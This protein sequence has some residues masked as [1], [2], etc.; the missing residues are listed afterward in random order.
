M[1]VAHIN[2]FGKPRANIVGLT[3]TLMVSITILASATC[4][5]TTTTNSSM[6]INSDSS[7]KLAVVG[8]NAI[9]TAS[10]MSNYKDWPMFQHDLKR[11]G[12]SDSH[13]P[14]T[15]NVLWLGTTGGYI[16]SSPAVKNGKVFVGSYDRHVYAFDCNDGS[17]IWRTMIGDPGGYGQQIYASPA[18]ANGLVFIGCRGIENNFYALYETNGTIKWTFSAEGPVD[19]SPAVANNCVYFGSYDKHVYAIDAITGKLQWAHNTATDGPAPPG[20]LGIRSSPA[21]NISTGIVYI[22]A[23]NGFVYAFDIEGFHDG[24]NDGWSGETGTDTSPTSTKADII[25]RKY[26]GDVILAS[27][28]LAKDLVIIGCNDHKLYA[29]NANNGTIVWATY[30]GGEIRSSAAVDEQRNL[31]VVGTRNYSVCALD[32]DTGKQ[33]WMVKTN[34]WVD[35]S[36]AIA[37]GMVFVGS[38]DHMVYALDEVTGDLIWSYDAQGMVSSSPAIADGRLFIGSDNGTLFAFGTPDLKLDQTDIEFS[39]PEPY[40]GETIEIITTIHNIGEVGAS[41]LVE[42]YYANYNN[43]IRGTIGSKM[44][45]VNARSIA[46]ITID[47]IALRPPHPIYRAWY[48]WVFITATDPAEANKDNNAAFRAIEVLPLPTE[49]WWMFQRDPAHL[50]STSDKGSDTNHI[51]WIFDAGAPIYTSPTVMRGRVFIGTLDKKVYAL[52]EY[53]RTEPPMPPG[54]DE[55]TNTEEPIEAPEICWYYQTNGK[56]TVSPATIYNK[57]FIG[58]NDGYLYALDQNGI[59]DSNMPPITD[60]DTSGNADVIWTFYA[61]NISG[62]PT[63]ANGTVYITAEGGVLYAIDEDNGLE[64]WRFNAGTEIPTS[65]AIAEHLLVIGTLAGEVIAIDRR[66]GT[67][68]WCYPTAGSIYSSPTIA[69][70]MVFIGSS[71]GAIYALDA[72]PDDN[73]DGV[74]DYTGLYPDIDDG[75]PEPA[76]VTYDLIWKYVTAGEVRASPAIANNGMLIVG[77]ADHYVYALNMY[78][79]SLIWKFETGD[80]VTG[81]PAIAY[82]HDNISDSKV[83]IGSEDHKIYALPLIDPDN[84]GIITD[85]ETIWSYELST[86]IIT[87]PAIDNGYVFVATTDGMLYAFG[88]PNRAPVAVIDAP[89]NGTKYLTTAK[90]IFDARS[91]YDP[92]GDELSYIWTSSLCVEPI[93]TQPIFTTTLTPGKHII[94]L[95]VDD[96]HGGKAVAKVT[97]IIYEPRIRTYDATILRPDKP[98]IN[99]SCTLCYGGEIG[100]VNI[101]PVANPHPEGELNGSLGIFVQIMPEMIEVMAWANITITYTSADLPYRMNEARLEMYYWHDNRWKLCSKNNDMY[102]TRTTGVDVNNKYV[103]ANVT[104]LGYIY[105]PG[106]F[107]N[108][109]PVLSQSKVTRIGITPTYRFSVV[110]TDLDNE[111]PTYIT[112][113]IDNTIQ[114]PMK[115]VAIYDKIPADGNEY[116]V[117]GIY[118]RPGRHYYMFDANDG[119]VSATIGTG[120]FVYNITNTIPVANAGAD[121][122]VIVNEPVLFSAYRSYDPDDDL[123]GNGRIDGYEIDNLSYTWDFNGD[124]IIDSM[125]KEAYYKYTEDGNYRVTLIVTDTDGGTNKTIINVIV[126]PGKLLPT[127]AEIKVGTYIVIGIIALIIIIVAVIIAK[128]QHDRAVRRDLERLWKAAEV[129]RLTEEDLRRLR[130]GKLPYMRKRER[131]VQKRAKGVVEAREREEKEK[132]EEAYVCETCGAPVKLTDRSCPECGRKFEPSE[133]EFEC[134]NCGAS[135]SVTDEVCPSCGSIFA[136]TGEE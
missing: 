109:P 97:V 93:S 45:Y 102:T 88:A 12:Y 99:A 55:N 91:S 86:K 26:I 9:L 70:G 67:Q 120:P 104:T 127:I 123:N 106:T 113:L 58:S 47:W 130:G 72:Y 30:L 128:I 24:Y 103:W 94:T 129:K 44:V 21:I 34:Y 111:L 96:G 3:I 37:D 74:I 115:P 56:I 25:W 32:L 39:D 51:K 13:A 52:Y 2:R 98:P 76:N 78:D 100:T 71:D 46:E 7:E 119:T 92:D 126:N 89:A 112:I 18:V 27:P 124:E 29:L 69:N 77:S 6:S 5:F 79:G 61:G 38:S 101:S 57:V 23:D 59:Y 85:L 1:R 116:E 108:H 41:A 65:P 22:G 19:S 60:E 95:I 40:E 68:L 122:W 110:Y 121:R 63:V 134:M 83:F 16:K 131:I 105:A 49:G 42:F 15:A 73:L 82:I 80:N 50:G 84:D 36:P 17:V 135:V 125:E 117:T 54:L 31:V 11:R 53:G 33:R 107:K 28:T 10:K 81:S 136:E 20:S 118:L 43:S 87:S 133:T 62:A 75:M 4:A 90:I 132:E 8:E 114:L 64:L 35:S 14:A 66:N 48:I